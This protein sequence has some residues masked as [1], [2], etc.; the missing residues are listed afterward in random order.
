MQTNVVRAGSSNSSSKKGSPIL[1]HFSPRRSKDRAAQNIGLHKK[2]RMPDVNMTAAVSMNRAEISM[3]SMPIG[4]DAIRSNADDKSRYEMKSVIMPLRVNNVTTQRSGTLEQTS[5]TTTTNRPSMSATAHSYSSDSDIVPNTTTA[6]SA[7]AMRRLYF[8]SAKLS[9]TMQN[10][11]TT[12]H[13]QQAQ[14]VPKVEKLL[15]SFKHSVQII[16]LN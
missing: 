11:I 14:H 4:G 15:L 7:T 6:S 9:K 10:S 2:D 12:V 13:Q 16:V 8:K 3:K 1:T 5:T